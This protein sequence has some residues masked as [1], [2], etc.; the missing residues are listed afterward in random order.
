MRGL[1]CC[2]LALGAILLGGCIDGQEEIFIGADGT[3][4]VKAIY[5][6]PAMIFSEKD[7]ED[8]KATIDQEVGG[9]ENLKLITNKVEKE[10]A[11]RVITLEIQ[12]DDLMALGEVLPEHPS[13]EEVSNA[14]KIWHVIVGRIKVNMAG[15]S[16]T[17][18]RD[19][20]LGPLLDEH[21]GKSSATLLGDAQFRYT[22]HLPEAA[23]TSNA[24][25]VVNEGRTLKWIYNLSECGK[26]PIS[27]TMVAPMQ[28][29]LW[30]YGVAAVLLMAIMWVI[31]AAV[32][33]LRS[34]NEEVSAVR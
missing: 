19:V 20:D 33:R 17:M 16:V 30:I 4:R 32:R 25:E 27:L 10:N 7:G 29:P 28:W 31:Y 5:R 11:E 14:D 8:L 34:R 3:A 21:L 23:E 6:M 22:I 12:T 9:H 2:L 26:N 24:H 1:F 15:L 18:S 13:D